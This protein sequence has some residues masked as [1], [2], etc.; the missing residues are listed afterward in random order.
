[1]FW[2]G[3]VCCVFSTADAKAE[4]KHLMVLTKGKRKET[5]IKLYFSKIHC[6]YIFVFQII[7]CIIFI[8]DLTYLIETKESPIN[9]SGKCQ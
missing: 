3:L 7:N 4:P 8:L 9:L 2:L 5:R 6:I 1:M